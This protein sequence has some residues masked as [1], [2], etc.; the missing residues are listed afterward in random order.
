MT[1]RRDDQAPTNWSGFAARAAGGLVLDSL[2]NGAVLLSLITLIAGVLTRSAGWVELGL[3]VG[4]A[5]IT[6]PWW[7]MARRWGDRRVVVVALGVLVAEVTT[8]AV[9]W[10]YA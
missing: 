1:Q 7:A 9:L 6:L 2:L 5:G 3:V 4:L 8:M 10:G